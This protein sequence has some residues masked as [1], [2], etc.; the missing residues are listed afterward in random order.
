M[1]LNVLTF[2]RVRRELKHVEPAPQQDP[3]SA[4]RVFALRPRRLRVG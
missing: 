4:P 3:A 2:A 1:K